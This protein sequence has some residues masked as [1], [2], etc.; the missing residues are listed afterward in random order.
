MFSF[1]EPCNF[2][3]KSLS[4]KV[5]LMYLHFYVIYS[6]ATYNIYFEIINLFEWLIFLFI[7]NIILYWLR[8][9]ISILITKI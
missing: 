7:S 1:Y 4:L 5:L 8:N 2:P 6:F 9:L 3:L